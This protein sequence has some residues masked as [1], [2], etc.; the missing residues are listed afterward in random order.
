MAIFTIKDLTFSYPDQ[1]KAALQ[2]ISLTVEDGD[3]VVICG[4]SGCG[5]STLL[6]HFKTALTPYGTRSGE[7]LYKDITLE[8]VSARMQAKEI[9][10]VTQN[11]DN[12]I[13][14]DKVWH[15]MAFGLENL[16]VDQKS[17]RLRVAEMA[18]YFGIQNWFDMDV[19]SLSGG[20]KQL[21]NLASVMAMQPEI[22][23][24]DEPTSQLDPIAASDFLQTVRKINRDL[25]LTVIITEHRLEEVFPVAD[26]VVVMENGRIK[27]EGSPREIGKN[28]VD[29][30]MFRAFP[31]TVRIY[32][33]LGKEGECPLTVREGCRWITGYSDEHGIDGDER[34]RVWKEEN[35]K[36]ADFEGEEILSVQ[37]GWFRYEKNGEDILRGLDISV[38]KGQIYAVLGGNGTGK[39]TALS[40][41]GGINR[42]YR[43]KVLLKGRELK[44]YSSKELHGSIIGMLPQNP[45]CL[46]VCDNVYDDLK[47][48]F[49]EG[50]YL[51]K[52]EIE[53][54]VER[55]AA[56][57]EITHLLK[58]HP[59]DLS[60]GEQQRAA[61]AKI[62]L[63]NPEI[64]LLDEATKGMDG[65]YRNKLG[66]ILKKLQ[67]NGHTIVMVSHDVEF[68]AEYADRC[69]MF[70]RGNVVAEK[71]AGEFFVG[72]SFYTTAANKMARHLFKDAVTV[73][74]VIRLC[75]Q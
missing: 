19:S 29:D 24:L 38:M 73:E 14:T 45:Q 31:T 18:S 34:N 9:G 8:K 27:A 58:A 17:M 59:Y 47:E 4:K 71:S 22:L 62:L 2:G 12:Q 6:K 32:A 67:A 69:G 57:A 54:R 61:L 75:R 21:L 7:I 3:F 11:P 5:K 20:Q 60:G 39:S 13:V 64:L 35:S 26:R 53:E 52:G 49:S 56:E 51:P 16:G 74:D 30:D 68:C 44:K 40:V 46:F 50:E 25:G 10:Y 41:M 1:T 36:D 48:M 37:N 66:E 15:E 72:N 28:L 65:F 23:I 33:G 42:P 63:K 55:A 43:G 70:F